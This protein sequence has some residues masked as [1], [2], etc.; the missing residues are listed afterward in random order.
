MQTVA[1]MRSE[2]TPDT[3]APDLQI[4]GAG[5]WPGGDLNI[6]IL[7]GGVV[8]PRSRGRVWLRS[9][10][11]G[12]PPHIDLGYYDDAA[13]MPRHVELL[14]RMRAIV[15]T[16]KVAALTKEILNGPASDDDAELEGYIRANC[17]TYHHPVGTCAMGPVV[18]AHGRV[19]GVDN[20]SV[21]DASI[22]PSIPSANTH[23]PTV[24]IAEH[25]AGRVLD[26]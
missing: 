17:W 12:D 3:S 1:T 21:I 7:A 18:D 5:P 8:K 16:P 11:A 25:L 13:D 22:M 24:M 19:H 14:R 10:D 6:W 9:A 4:F 23:L 15:G 2:G 20:L 26:R